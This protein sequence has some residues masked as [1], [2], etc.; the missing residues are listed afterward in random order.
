MA[1]LERG[2]D[3]R[4]N[5]L[6]TASPSLTYR[7]H[8]NKGMGAVLLRIRHKQ[9]VSQQQVA[10][11]LGVTQAMVSRWEAGKTAIDTDTLG[12]WL[13]LLD[14]SKK[15]KSMLMRDAQRISEF[16]N[17]SSRN[18][19]TMLTIPEYN[20][21]AS[22]GGGEF[23]G[24]EEVVE[25]HSLPE[26]F[27][28]DTNHDRTGI[29]RINGDSMYPTIN[30]GDYVVVSLTGKFY[31]DGIYLIRIDNSV[32]CKRLQ[33]R[34]DGLFVISD[35]PAYSEIQIDSDDSDSFQ[36]LGRVILTMKKH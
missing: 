8:S 34:I 12:N 1:E 9:G 14:V 22:A 24:F 6:G 31:E 18:K 23:V 13:Q 30:S 27:L 16:A 26:K 20:V 11:E 35:N 36:V 25:Y 32:Y 19:S 10:D 29:V 21:S 4:W 17:K 15:E 5:F 33:R 3:G 2:E 7:V 28:P